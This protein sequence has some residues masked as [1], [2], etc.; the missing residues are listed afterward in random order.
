MN[1]SKIRIQNFRNF[2]NCEFSLDQNGVIVGENKSGKTNLLYA[3]R[4]VLDP[5]LSEI[6]RTLRVDDFWDG[7]PRPLTADD[8][9]V[10]EIELANYSKNLDQITVLGDYLIE[11]EPMTAMLGYTFRPIP[12]LSHPPRSESDYESICYGGTSVENGFGSE[13]RSQLPITVLPALRDAEGDLANWRHSP[14][15]PLLTRV[16]AEADSAELKKVSRHVTEAT[17]EL[18]RLDGVENLSKAILDRFEDMV[19]TRHAVDLDLGFA[20]TDA[21]RLIRSL[22]LF[23]DGRTRGIADASLGCANIIYLTL[24][25]LE[26]ERL[27]LEGRRSHTFLAIEEPEAHLHPHLQRL[28]FRD[29]FSDTSN[30]VEQDSQEAESVE[31]DKAGAEN[32]MRSVLLTT[33]SPNIVSVAPVRSLILLRKDPQNGTVAFSTAN[34]EFTA[35]DIDD[36][37]RYLDVNRGEIVFAS[38]VLLVE[39][40]AEQYLIPAFALQIGYDF[41]KLGISVC[42]VSGTNFLPYIKLLGDKGLNVPLA[43]ITDLD[44]SND[45]TTLGIPRSRKLLEYLKPDEPSVADADAKKVGELNS[46]FLNENTLEIDLLTT[47]AMIPMLRTLCTLT[48]NGAAQER[49]KAWAKDATQLDPIQFMK[50]LKEVGKGHFAQRLSSVLKPEYCPEYIKRAIENIVAKV[51]NP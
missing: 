30:D 24:L 1:I 32:V 37:Q 19:G 5:K 21:Q 46:I 34:A 28:V 18:A 48:S 8:K 35:D 45:G 43:V 49:C 36:L 27:V 50:D 23:I 16:A 47:D 10:I 11:P 14:L 42:S 29:F 20:P 22:R 25:T 41:D 13:V 2:R 26:L 15:R 7:L 51:S 4:L 12:T 3:L 40:I 33:H 44:P 39:G 38:G 17:D 6:D 31:G 9:I